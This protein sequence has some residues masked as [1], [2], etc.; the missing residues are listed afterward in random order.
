[1]SVTNSKTTVKFDLFGAEKV[2]VKGFIK[3]GKTYVEARDL[4][5]K[6]EFTVGWDSANKTVLVGIKK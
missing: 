2:D 5:E 6:M 1:M 3:D 4:L